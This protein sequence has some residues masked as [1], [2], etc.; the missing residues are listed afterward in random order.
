MVSK[1]IKSSKIPKLTEKSRKQNILVSQNKPKIN[2]HRFS[3][4]L[5]RSETKFC[6]LF[7]GHPRFSI[8]N[9]RNIT[10]KPP[11]PQQC[12]IRK[13]VAEPHHFDA[14]PAPGKNFDAAP[15][16]APTLLFSKTKFLK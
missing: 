1:Q 3:F 12:T 11:A 5:F 16:P 10:I 13:S 4:G 6:C 8:R 15:A 2:R 14:A 9:R 7:R